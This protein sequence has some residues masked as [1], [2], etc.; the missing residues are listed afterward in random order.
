[1]ECIKIKSIL[2]GKGIM[3]SPVRTKNN[4]LNNGKTRRT[5]GT[6]VIRRRVV[7]IR[8]LNGGANGK[9]AVPRG[10]DKKSRGDRKW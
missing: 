5:C 2:N 8:L 10:E 3:N 4:L 9:A 1:M 6:T 7:Q